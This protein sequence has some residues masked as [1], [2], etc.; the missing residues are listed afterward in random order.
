MPTGHVGNK[1]SKLDRE[2]N[3]SGGEHSKLEKAWPIQGV[4][5]LLHLGNC[6]HVRRWDQYDQMLNFPR[7]ARHQGFYVKSSHF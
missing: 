1:G 3:G 4:W 2:A 5:P 7:E 6:S